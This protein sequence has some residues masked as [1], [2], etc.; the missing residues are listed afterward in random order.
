MLILK[1]ARLPKHTIYVALQLDRES[2]LCKI[3]RGGERLDGTELKY[4]TVHGVD[5][6]N[7]SDVLDW[8][9]NCKGKKTNRNGGRR[10]LVLGVVGGKAVAPAAPISLQSCSF[11]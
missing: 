4:V 9:Q 11:P 3:A 2:T 1:I 10:F 6:T 7:Q 5:T 8:A